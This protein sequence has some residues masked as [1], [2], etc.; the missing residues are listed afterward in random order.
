MEAGNRTDR[1]IGQELS[2]ARTMMDYTDQVIASIPEDA[3]DL[4]FTD[5][6]GGYFFSAREL[7][8]HIADSR[9][10]AT[11]SVSGEDVSDRQ[12]LREYGGLEKPWKFA[13]GNKGEI[14]AWLAEGRASVEALLERPADQMHSVSEHQL[15]T[16]NQRIKARKE[17]GLDS[18]SLEASGPP[19]LADVLLFLVAHEQAHR[20]ELQWLM[21]AHGKDVHR[22][23]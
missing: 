11:V 18:S 19:C 16:H 15:E 8:M 10:N 21:R 14:V 1:T 2:W 13:D 20:S 4:R 5:P 3:L 6:K 22:L 12:F 9:W 17:Q 7:M 23:V